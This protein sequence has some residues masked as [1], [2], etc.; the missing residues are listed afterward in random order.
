MDAGLK[1]RSIE[2]S[3]LKRIEEIDNALVGSHRALSWPLAAEANW[4]VKRPMLNFVAEVDGEVVG[5]LLGDIRAVE[6][7]TSK[8]GW[9]DIIGVMP[10]H[11]G[12][13]IGKNLVAAFCE[14]CQKAGAKV[15]IVIRG[16]DKRLI[17]FWTTVGFHK[18]NLV[19]YEK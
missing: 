15:R 10:Q 8:S 19:S 18:G 11:Q 12:R 2:A 17:D 9:I 6:F 1:I 13:G 5:F 4:W 14:E 3:D 7:G 16:D